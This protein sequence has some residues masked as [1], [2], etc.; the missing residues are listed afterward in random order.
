MPPSSAL[1]RKGT[2]PLSASIGARPSRVPFPSLY[3]CSG[4]RTNQRTWEC[5][6]RESEQQNPDLRLVAKSIDPQAG[7]PNAGE[8]PKDQTDNST[9]Y[10]PVETVRDS[11]ADGTHQGGSNNENNT[12]SCHVEIPRPRV[13]ASKCSPQPKQQAA[14]EPPYCPGQQSFYCA[15][16]ARCFYCALCARWVVVR[17]LHEANMI[18]PKRTRQMRMPLPTIHLRLIVGMPAVDAL[19]AGSVQ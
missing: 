2:T 18:T 4:S 10:G 9:L 12:A 13:V 15:L 17:A 5:A 16:C 8:N 11:F 19:R 3:Q 6:R 7:C 1:L 14:W